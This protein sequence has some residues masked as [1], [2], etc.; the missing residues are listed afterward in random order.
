MSNL[1]L[2]FSKIL[3]NFICVRVRQVAFLSDY[4]NFIRLKQCSLYGFLF[5]NGWKEKLQKIDGIKRVCPSQ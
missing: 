2:S 3:K 4:E 1:I 5:R